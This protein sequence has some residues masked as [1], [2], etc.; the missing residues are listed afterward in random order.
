MP[1]GVALFL[2]LCFLLHKRFLKMQICMLAGDGLSHL[3]IVLLS[4]KTLNTCQT[5][6]DNLLSGLLNVGEFV[7]Y[8]PNLVCR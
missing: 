6:R 3:Q 2:Q 1:A 7:F 8:C 4:K 5:V